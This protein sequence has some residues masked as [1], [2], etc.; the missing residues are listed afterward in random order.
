MDE[1]V[2]RYLVFRGQVDKFREGSDR[3]DPQLRAVYEQWMTIM[4]WKD[5][6]AAFSIY[7]RLNRLLHSS[8]VEQLVGKVQSNGATLSGNVIQFR[9]EDIVRTIGSWMLGVPVP[10]SYEIVIT[11]K[12][13]RITLPL[14][15]LERLE[16]RYLLSNPPEEETLL[17]LKEL[18]SLMK[19]E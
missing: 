11:R 4:E 5:A 1:L 13:T 2:E 3:P 8:F 15:Q 16:T 14:L 7:C 12:D 9:G 18:I 10:S 19:S 17:I 6:R